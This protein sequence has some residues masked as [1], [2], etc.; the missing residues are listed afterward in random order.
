MAKEL[1]LLELERGSIIFG[2]M[3][4]TGSLFRWLRDWVEGSIRG[5]FEDAVESMDK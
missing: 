4:F 5:A 1:C 3:G 2:Q